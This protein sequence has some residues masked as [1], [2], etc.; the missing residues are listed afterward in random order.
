[1]K[2]RR[3]LALLSLSVIFALAACSRSSTIGQSQ[4]DSLV[5]KSLSFQ[6]E[7]NNN[8]ASDLNPAPA[9]FTDATVEIVTAPQK[10]TV[11]LNGTS[12]NYEPDPYQ[13]GSDRFEYRI[14]SQGVTSSPAEV[15]IQMDPFT[16]GSYS[17]TESF[18]GG[19][20]DLTGW[21]S[22]A[23]HF[24]HAAGPNYGFTTSTFNAVATDLRTI[25]V[26][27]NLNTYGG[28]DLYNQIFSVLPVDGGGGGMYDMPWG[29]DLIKLPKCFHQ[30]EMVTKI[31]YISAAPLVNLLLNYRI[32][33]TSNVN[34]LTGYQL[35]V[36]SGGNTVTLSKFNNAHERITAY[37]DRWPLHPAEGSAN[38]VRYGAYN[39]WNRTV[40]NFPA[41]ANVNSA[42]RDVLVAARYAYDPNTLATQ[43]SFEVRTD[44]GVDN[45]PG[46]WDV[47]VNLTG[48]DSLP[49]GGSFGF[50]PV[51][52]HN[53]TGTKF[54]SEAGIAQFSF[55]CE[56]P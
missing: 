31:K 50:M 10:G 13:S 29:A 32:Q 20:Y 36:N 53:S 26:S 55:S 37:I 18:V 4:L 19:D 38:P 39:G 44:A 11:T 54:D 45:T 7:Q 33:T 16:P 30:V 40:G 27:V 56:V 21:T 3:V 17:F 52:Y 23:S 47:T 1:M 15:A 34:Y 35:L 48:T 24:G 6:T 41:G 9:L 14:R 49:P 46:S 25:G 22:Y 51:T 28:N 43:I 2:A 12:F 42:Q 8:V 5:P